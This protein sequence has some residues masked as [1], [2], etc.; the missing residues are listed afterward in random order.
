MES[1]YPDKEICS[2][3][4]AKNG[5]PKV[6]ARTG[7]SFSY[8]WDRGFVR[9]DDR[10]H[11][12][13]VM[14]YHSIATP[15][16]DRCPELDRLPLSAEKE[17]TK[18]KEVCLKCRGEQPFF[19]EHGVIQCW[20][21]KMISMAIVSTCSQTGKDDDCPYAVEHAVSLCKTEDNPV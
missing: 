3:C 6:R 13:Q 10:E 12:R 14:V 21:A 17:A 20:H 7:E 11:L 19:D 15:V 18:A 2:A 4:F 8:C 9:C 1:R 16:F 5:K